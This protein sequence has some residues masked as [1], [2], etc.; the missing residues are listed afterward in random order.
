MSWAF[1]LA[2]HNSSPQVSALPSPLVCASL[3]GRPL[4]HSRWD[5]TM[6][7]QQRVVSTSGEEVWRCFIQ[8]PFI[9]A[10]GSALKCE[11]GSGHLGMRGPPLATHMFPACDEWQFFPASP[12]RG[13]G[14]L[15]LAR[16][17]LPKMRAIVGGNRHQHSWNPL[18]PSFPWKMALFTA[19]SH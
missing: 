12:P 9:L 6:H 13:S 2:S 3:C 15:F 14:Q 7:T 16:K 11:P 10:L 4:P 19:S 18:L 1:V 5:T 17:H 8:G